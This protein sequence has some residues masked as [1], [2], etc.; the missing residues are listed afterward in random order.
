MDCEMCGKYEAENLILVEGAKLT[1]CRRC[2]GHG[3]VLFSLREQV[4][5][6]PST[7]SS[8]PED[9]ELVDDYARR[10]R[11][12]REKMQLTRLQVG[13]K[14]SEKENYLEAIEQGRVM[15]TLPTI[16]KL[17]KFLG[18]T[19]LEK[20]VEGGMGE[21]PMQHGGGV[22]LGEL[23]VQNPKKLKKKN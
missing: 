21:L 19:L 18:I 12:A 2:S 1:A 13:Q 11:G 9:E 7:P 10:I 16:R 17:E 8:M 20:N 6:K 4:T 3:K 23:L 14:I 15:P 5:P 22:T